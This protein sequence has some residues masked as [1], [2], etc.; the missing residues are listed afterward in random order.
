MGGK[1]AMPHYLFT[2]GP[3]PLDP[4]IQQAFAAPMMNHR[5]PRFSVLIRQIEEG[6]SVLIKSSEPMVV[7][8]TSG[9]GALECLLENLILPK[10]KVLSIS[11]GAFGDR[12]R[13]IARRLGACVVPYDVNWGEAVTPCESFVSFISRNLDAKAILLTQNETST[14]VV[15]DIA[16]LSF[17]I[18]SFFDTPPLLLVDAVSSLGA[19][20][21]FPEEWGIDGLAAASQKGLLTPPGLG[22][23]WLS[24]RAWEEAQRISPCRSFFFD[25]LEYRRE[26]GKE[27]PQTPYTPAVPLFYALKKALDLLLAEGIETLFIQRRRFAD[28][29]A[30]GIEAMGLELLVADPK[31]RSAGVTA[32][33]VVEGKGN[34]LQKT[35]RGM[36]VEVAGGQGPLKGSLVRMAHYVPLAWP[37]MSLMLGS[38]WAAATSLEIR[39]SDAFLETAWKKW[40]VEE[41]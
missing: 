1:F 37:D 16:A 4:S 22:L 34:V 9:T 27:H 19:M 35:L 10:D 23:V 11:C 40:K 36:G 21:C 6:L 14:G 17:F 5:E 20:P 41:K 18:R 28:A 24:S 31:A 26:L 8:P 38:L 30:A 12:F 25:L 32:I 33:K 15:N 7:L 2:P 13:E 29:F 39:V 3:V